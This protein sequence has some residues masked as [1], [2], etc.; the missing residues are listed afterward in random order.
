M[1]RY[2]RKQLISNWRAQVARPRIDLC[3][4]PFSDAGVS[5]TATIALLQK[6]NDILSES[7]RAGSI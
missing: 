5:G 1:W 6:A 3:Q 4:I 7:E 2:A